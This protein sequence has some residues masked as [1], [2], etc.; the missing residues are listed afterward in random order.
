MAPVKAR[1]LRDTTLSSVDKNAPAY[2]IIYGVFGGLTPFIRATGVAKSTAHEWV[3]TGLIP[4]PRQGH[5]LA[6]A[7]DAGLKLDPALF[8]PAPVA[9]E[10]R[11]A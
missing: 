5:V 2:R 10:Q 3:T 1:K 8:V 6:K 9:D 4:S 7:K 11:A